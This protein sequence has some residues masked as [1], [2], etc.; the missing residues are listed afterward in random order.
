MSESQVD[1]RVGFFEAAE[2]LRVR[3]RPFAIAT[4][5]NVKGSASAKPGSKAL[6]DESGRNVWGWV[7]G[8]CA[9]S[10]VARNAVEAMGEGRTRIIQADLDDEVFGLGMPCGGI[11][12][13]YIEPQRPLERIE[14]F[15]A[16]ALRE[17]AT[18]FARTMAFQASFKALDIQL[19]STSGLERT[20]VAIARA[21]SQSRGT[22]FESLKTVRGIYRDSKPWANSEKFSEL[23]IVGSSRITEELAKFG[24][25]A[26]WP[27]RVY[28]WNLDSANYPVAAHLEESDAG[29]KNFHVKPGSAVIVASHHKGDYDFIQT[30]LQSRANYVGLVAS[31]KRAGLIFEH[32]QSLSTDLPLDRIFAPAGYEMNCNGPQEIALSIIAEIIGLKSGEIRT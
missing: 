12:D 4:V 3:N 5:I 15:E 21:I 29:F 20:L 27:V 19:G 22:S 18:T 6:I 23:L 32:I 31:T 7:G 17:P 26:K 13:V 8:G 2:S 10:F 14:I 30:A 24:A 11:M 28:G 1:S 25:M 16:E 9:E